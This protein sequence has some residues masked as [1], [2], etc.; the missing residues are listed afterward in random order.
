MSRLVTGSYYNG[1][2]TMSQETSFTHVK[3]HLLAAL[4]FLPI[5]LAHCAVVGIFLTLYIVHAVLA[6][7]LIYPKSADF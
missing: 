4:F 7:L 5:P 3:L 1:A 2:P 6:G